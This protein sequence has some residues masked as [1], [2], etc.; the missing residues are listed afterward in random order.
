MRWLF[1]VFGVGLVALLMRS[2]KHVPL[3]I[4]NNNPGNIENNGIRWQGLDDTQEGRFY[5]FVSPEYG[6]RAMARIMRTYSTKY[7]INTINGIIS[8]W[9]PPT[10]NDTNSYINHVSSVLGVAPDEYFDVFDDS[11]LVEL[12]AVITKHENGVQ[13]Y[14]KDLILSGVAMA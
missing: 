5:R 9:A 8:R 12:L 6:F 2:D 1:G 14:E 3:G 7:G 11:R 10:E 4:R 13:P